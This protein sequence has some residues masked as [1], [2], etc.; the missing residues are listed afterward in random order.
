MQQGRLDL[1]RF[2][3]KSQLTWFVTTSAKKKIVVFPI[4]C[5]GLL[6]EQL[7]RDMFR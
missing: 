4:V 2:P 6:G 3:T 1:R 5:S 7:I